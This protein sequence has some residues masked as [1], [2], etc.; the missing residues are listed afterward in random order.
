MAT[1]GNTNKT[2][3]DSRQFL[4]FHLGT[5]MYGVPLSSIREIIS[6]VKITPIPNTAPFV[7]GVIN[8]RGR[9]VPIIE[10]RL[11]FGMPDAADT[12]QTCVIVVDVGSVQMGVIV[13]TV[14]EVI[15][16]A[17]STIEPPPVLGDP[18]STN[19]ILGVGKYNDRVIILVDLADSLSP[20][21]LNQIISVSERHSGSGA[22]SEAA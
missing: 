14:S 7:R 3:E 17:P 22:A 20:E 9:I 4:T 21:K 10:L 12:K 2:T 19:F 6:R 11:K 18:S 1:R 13:D 16:L 8:L 15:A 5:E